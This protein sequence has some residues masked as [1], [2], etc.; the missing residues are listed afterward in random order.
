[1]ACIPGRHGRLCDGKCNENCGI[2]EGDNGN[3]GLCDRNT[4]LCLH[5]CDKG[6]Y[7]LTCLERCNSKCRGETCN[8]DNG[9]CSDGCVSGYK[10]EY[11]SLLGKN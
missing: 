1:M 11:C 7:N 3:V 5:G 8:R 6:W 4:S 9:K 2:A 10:G